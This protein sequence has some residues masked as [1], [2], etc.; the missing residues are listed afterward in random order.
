MTERSRATVNAELVFDPDFQCAVPA[1]RGA[2]IRRTLPA[3][4]CAVGG[5]RGVMSA[6]GH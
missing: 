4:T 1:M 3:R 5:G 2:K 6:F